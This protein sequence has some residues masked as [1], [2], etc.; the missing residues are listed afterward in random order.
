MRAMTSPDRS[1]R[2]TTRLLAGLG[3]VALLV[4]CAVAVA[5]VVGGDGERSAAP[6]A[7]DA[8]TTPKPEPSAP[9][10]RVVGVRLAAAGTYDP[11]GD[12]AENDAEAPL[13]VDGDARTA[14][15]TE[16]YQ[17]FFKQG[18][19]LVLDAGA[20]RRLQ[21][22]DLVTGTPGVSAAVQVGD[23]P[24]GPFR[25]VTTARTLAETTR[26]PLGGARGRYV[27]VWI[28][29]IPD[30]GAAEIAEARLRARS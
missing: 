28:T 18:V 2:T 9:R 26:I 3:L 6:V 20:V 27:V 30:G 10:V 29:A 15:S 5:P 23:A 14:W 1:A 25:P 7:T 21:R 24:D 19:G 11:E 8:A 13:A 16:S 22:L 17:S 12:Q 4:A